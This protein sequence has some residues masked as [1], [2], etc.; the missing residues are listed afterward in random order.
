MHVRPS[1]LLCMWP[2]TID[3]TWIVERP[4]A[5]GALRVWDAHGGPTVLESDAIGPR[6]RAEVAIERPVLLHHHD[7]VLDLV[8][9]DESRDLMR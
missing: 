4:N 9:P 5:V 7:H 3:E 8:D 2:T 1:G 6:V